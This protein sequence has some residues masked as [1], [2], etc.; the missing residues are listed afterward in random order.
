MINKEQIVFQSEVV[1]D[2]EINIGRNL[3]EAQATS[4]KDFRE[5]KKE[6]SINFSKDRLKRAM[7]SAKLMILGA[8]R[9][10]VEN[11]KLS[12][13]SLLTGKK[14]DDNEEL[15][16]LR[17]EFIQQR[18]TIEEFKEKYKLILGKVPKTDLEKFLAHL[19]SME[20]K[21][22]DIEF[23]E[24]ERENIKS[25]INLILGCIE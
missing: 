13:L 4:K 11:L 2:D 12:E 16:N 19:K 18:I 6:V 15:I 8:T 25:K 23:P 14:I 21:V 20:D 1:V 5:L 3:V 24:E 9:D 7:A 10:L 17:L 22:M